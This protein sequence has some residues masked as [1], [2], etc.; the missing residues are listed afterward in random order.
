M[1][2]CV[3]EIH[4]FPLPKQY[5]T[6]CMATVLGRANRLT[7]SHNCVKPAGLWILANVSA[8][9]GAYKLLSSLYQPYCD[10]L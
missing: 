10:Q 8:G 1:L 9:A 6:F 3:S 7:D 4:C 2:E 5:K